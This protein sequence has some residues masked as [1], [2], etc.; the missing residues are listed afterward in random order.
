MKIILLTIALIVGF[1]SAALA[2][3]DQQTPSWEPCDYTDT[4][5]CG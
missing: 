1:A 4:N 5:S 3:P 2:G